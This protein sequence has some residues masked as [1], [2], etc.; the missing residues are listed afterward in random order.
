M[1]K[2]KFDLKNHIL[3]C[4]HNCI[5][6]ILLMDLLAIENQS[7]LRQ[8]QNHQGRESD[9]SNSSIVLRKRH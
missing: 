5:T 6:I 2:F 7:M 4:N 3:W 8:S 1:L 9:S